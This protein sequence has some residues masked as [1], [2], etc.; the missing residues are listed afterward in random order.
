MSIQLK[1]CLQS[2]DGCMFNTKLLWY[3]LLHL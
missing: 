1:I 2:Q 3:L